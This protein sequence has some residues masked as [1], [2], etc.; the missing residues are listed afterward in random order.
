MSQFIKLWHKLYCNLK[1]N[2]LK[3]KCNICRKLEF[4]SKI[5]FNP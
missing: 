3:L 5:E 4:D 1:F 2:M